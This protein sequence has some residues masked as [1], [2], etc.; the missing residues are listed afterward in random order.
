[1]FEIVIYSRKLTKIKFFKV[2]KRIFQH[3][4]NGKKRKCLKYYL[5][6]IQHTCGY[7]NLR[8]KTSST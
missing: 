6:I 2:L 5:K 1:M 7:K 4:F 8:K 3:F